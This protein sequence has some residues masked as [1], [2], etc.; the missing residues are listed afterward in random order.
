M[1]KYNKALS[2]YESGD[3]V[4]AYTMLNEL[5][6][7]KD[8]STYRIKAYQGY[9][10]ETINDY[11]VGDYLIY[12]T[13]EQDNNTSNGKE[14][15]E[16]QILAKEENRI[17]LISRYA[18]DCQQYNSENVNVTWE[19]CSLRS[20][21]NS[22]FYDDAF[23]DA[24]KTCIATSIVTADPNLRYS[25]T[26][27]GNDTE[28]KIFLMS[29]KEVSKYLSSNVNMQS[30]ATEYAYGIGAYRSDNG[31]CR[32]WLRTSGHNSSLTLVINSDGYCDYA[33]VNVD[34]RDGAVRPALWINLSND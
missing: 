6:N 15:I 34:D 3:Y 11:S 19:T 14:D 10:K 25:T 23:S 28:D 33:G 32:W 5:G 22:T 1:M 29:I 31:N 21:L 9:L 12:G 16:W 8:A 20:W 13:Y 24:E 17:F 30:K 7:Y 27:Q 18:L 4:S 2:L 26:N